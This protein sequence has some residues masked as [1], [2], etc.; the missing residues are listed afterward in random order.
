[1]NLR[2]PLAPVGLAISLAIAVSAC[3]AAPANTPATSIDEPE[4]MSEAPSPTA[5]PTRE[6][7]TEAPSPTR[8]AV[9]TATAPADELL[10]LE[11]TDVRTGETF[12]LGQL[13]ADDGPV[14]LEPMAIWC[15][16]CRAQQHEVKRAHEEG[17]SFTSVSLDVELS[18]L[19]ED[20]AAYAQREGWDWRFALA[21]A[22]LYRLLQARFG[23]NATHPPS[24]PLIV[25]ERDG[26]VRA[27]EFGVGVRSA[28]EL[29]AELGAG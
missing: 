1:M 3:A 25:I 21:D 18:E 7:M 27:L 2:L 14:L 22:A 13:A 11:L 6:P 26:T 12:T 20:L 24:A 9:P 29:V 4:P 8:P 10:A 23:V 15:S 19:P 28:E 5:S 17:A 16:T